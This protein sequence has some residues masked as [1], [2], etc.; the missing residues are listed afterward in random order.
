MAAKRKPATKRSSAPVQASRR[1]LVQIPVFV[2]LETRK[3][4][5]AIALKL[6]R[7]TGELVAELIE[8]FVAKHQT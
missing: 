5:K 2:K 4:L 7:G 8:G 1:D 3:S 6:D